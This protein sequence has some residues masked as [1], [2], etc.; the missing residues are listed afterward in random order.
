MTLALLIRV[1]DLKPVVTKASIRFSETRDTASELIFGRHFH[2]SKG[3]SAFTSISIEIPP[4]KYTT[5][6]LPRSIF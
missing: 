3:R 4:C 2:E 5:T 1:V 6:Y